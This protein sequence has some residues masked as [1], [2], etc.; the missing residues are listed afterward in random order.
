MDEKVA[1]RRV[2]QLAF[3]R[4]EALG[5][6]LGQPRRVSFEHLPLSIRKPGADHQPAS[7]FPG[8]QRAIDEVEPTTAPVEALDKHLD[9]PATR[10]PDAPRCLVRYTESERLRTAVLQDLLSLGND[11]ALDA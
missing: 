8:L 4:A 2:E 6:V 10:Q 1:L 9:L 5:D 3:A 7:G 11:L